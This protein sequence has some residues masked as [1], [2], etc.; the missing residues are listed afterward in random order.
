M[1]RARYLTEINRQELERMENRYDNLDE[2]SEF[3]NKDHPYAADLDVFGKKSL[4][5][6]LNRTTSP[7]GKLILSEWLLSTADRNTI[8][9]RQSAIEELSTNIDWR[10]DLQASGM[11][12]VDKEENFKALLNWLHSTEKKIKPLTYIQAYALPVFSLTIA[13][14]VIFM[15]INFY[16]LVGAMLLNGLVLKQYLGKV[17]EITSRTS[18]SVK[19]LKTYGY[20]IQHIEESQFNNDHLQNLKSVFVHDNFSAS[21]SILQLQNILNYLNA[22][23]NMFYWII[24]LFLMFDIHLLIQVEKWKRTKHDDIDRW[25]NHIGEFE[26]LNSMAG[27][28]YANPDFTY[29]EIS[30]EPFEFKALALGH[31]LIYRGERVSNDF[32]TNNQGTVMIITGSNMSGKSTFLR[33]IGVNMVLALAGAPVCAQKMSTSIMQVF[34]SMR[35]EDNLEE[36]VSSFY[37]ELQRIQMLLKLLESGE[38]PILYML[39]EILKGTNSKDRNAGAEALVRQISLTGS[40]GLV[41]THDLKLG[42]LADELKNVH[43]YSFNSTI[44][45]DEIIFDYKISDGLC[46]SFNASKLMEKMGIKMKKEG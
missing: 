13:A 22:R 27:Y 17:Q 37:A 4:F 44:E 14:M 10:Q 9:S 42:D 16:F 31:P 7:S 28:A 38:R 34:T 18:N 20:L 39:D 46:H 6:M 25:F 1:R 35:T 36:H 40:M 30:E 11:H 8:L 12:Y 26:V 43:N 3:L 24:N 2:G 23:S 41:S 19:T 45:G 15:G 29:P 5:Q 21:K 33:S 32:E